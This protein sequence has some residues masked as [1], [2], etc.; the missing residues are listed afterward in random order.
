M[1]YLALQSQPSTIQKSQISASAAQ[2]SQHLAKRIAS[3]LKQNNQISVITTT[4]HEIDGLTALMHRAFPQVSLDVRLSKFGA[5]ANASLQL[6]LPEFIR[7]LNIHAFVLP[8]EQGLAFEQIT[9]G[10]LAISGPL[11]IKIARWLVNNLVQDG[12]ADKAL[13]MINA[14]EIN[15]QQIVAYIALKETLDSAQSKSILLT[16]RD[17]LALFG[18]VE[19]ISFY[20]QS[21]SEFAQSQSHQSSIAGFIRYL[22]ELARVRGTVT[23]NYVASEENQAALMALVI[24]FGADRFEQL[25]GDVI[26]RDHQSLVLRNRMRRNVTLQDRVDLQQHFIY[27]IALQLFSTHGASDAL[28]EFKEFLDT[29]EG[30]SGFSFADLQADR[31]GTRLAIIVTRSEQHATQAQQLLAK[32][33][34]QELL[35]S[36]NGLQEGLH[37]Q[38]FEQQ[39]QHADSQHYQQAIGEIDSRLKSLPVYQLGWE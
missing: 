29:N 8:S 3:T 20:Y 21:L 35:P 15:E 5:S 26:I 22:F 19:K 16:L 12:I 10:D 28:G 23:E 37:Q 7:Y 36:I 13:A 2:K 1:L 31:A 17:E 32:V 38:N 34:D 14:V 4:Q 18:D 27:S 30:G 9:V 24:Y 11:F 33:T 25:V 6:P 39:F